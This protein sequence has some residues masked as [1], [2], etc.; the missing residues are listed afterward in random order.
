[1]HVF[2]LQNAS[3]DGFHFSVEDSM[4]RLQKASGT[5]FKKQDKWLLSKLG[6]LIDQCTESYKEAR[7]SEAVRAIEGFV[8]DLLSQTYVPIVRGEMWEE[9]NEGKE[10]R[11]IIYSV[12]GLVLYQLDVM[13]HPV[14]PFVTDYLGRKVF[15]ADSFF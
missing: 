2:Y 10:R 8:I 13:L 1:M 12:L 5:T 4:K 9:T 6:L 7:Y 11:Q 15:G 3:F 14:S